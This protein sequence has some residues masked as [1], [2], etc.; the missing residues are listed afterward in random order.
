LKIGIRGKLFAISLLLI[1]VVG[2]TSGAFLESRLRNTLSARIEADLARRA[3]TARS[4]VSRAGDDPVAID[5]LAHE[6][7]RSSE[8]H[9]TIVD[10][11][12]R[13]LGDSTALDTEVV[14]DDS[15]I[16][17]ALA[18]GW[19]VSRRRDL[20]TGAQILFVATAFPDAETPH[21][22]VRLAMPLSEIDAAIAELRA[23]ILLAALV[24][25]ATAIFMSAFA[26]ELMSRALRTLVDN[27]VA[28]VRGERREKIPR[29]R[30]DELG[31]L[32]GSFNQI[33]SE[34]QK[35]VGDL[36][37]ERDRLQ[38]ILSSMHE[39]V[40]ALDRTGR[41]VL[42]NGA[43]NRL[44]GLDDD[45]IGK[46][47]LE[48]VRIPALAE[49]AEESRAGREAAREFEVQRPQAKQI[50]AHASPLRMVGGV[51]IVMHDITEI[52]RLERMRRDFVANVSHELRTPIAVIR[53]NAET[54]LAGALEDGPHAH[55]FVDGI[56]R[57]AERLGQLIADLLDLSRIEAG[58]Y[59]V[60][61]SDTDLSEAVGQVVDGLRPR[62]EE[63]EVEIENLIE[64]PLAVR[65]E[66]R[67]LEQIL[68]NY[69]DN[70]IKYTGPGSRIVVRAVDRGERLR[71]EVEDDGPGI[72]PHHRK[73]IFER[74]YRVDPG[75]ARDVGGTGLGLSIVKHLADAMSGSVGVEPAPGRG[76][77]FWVE[78]PRGTLA[79]P[80]P[81]PDE[82]V[83]LA[84]NR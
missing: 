52:R 24:G 60:V 75:R 25:L 84:T 77:L 59:E 27:A 4:A 6:L 83:S 64:E 32:A 13:V 47:L 31:R 41:V 2:I 1:A 20:I 23:L 58:R 14:S 18:T 73:R 35:A 12:G 62:S 53:A 21:G 42:A 33:A 45:D 71:I 65:A 7:G 50:L 22:V 61:L 51:V 57:N 82:R 70:A 72:E 46:P 8:A 78:L 74:F 63:R 26:S 54:L 66:P 15:E 11:S 28:V 40:L 17:E 29:M 68:T 80:Q 3:D 5:A 16:Q 67:A 55:R 44:L 48:A 81:A 69:L 9:V 36:A 39:A 30:G 34:L 19:G 43:L 56:H 37:G 38:T 10:P 49:L 76:A 79:E